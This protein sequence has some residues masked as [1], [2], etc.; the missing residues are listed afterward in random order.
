LLAKVTILPKGRIVD[1][2]VGVH[3]G[4]LTWPSDPGVQVEPVSRVALGDPAS[5]SQ[6]HLGSHTGTHVDPP[7]HF[8]KEGSTVDELPLDALV[9]P[10]S[11]VDLTGTSGE[12]T[13][14][15]LAQLGLPAGVERILLKTA[16]SKIWQEA[17]PTFPGEYIALSPDAAQ[18][19]VERG[20]RLVGT[21]FLSIETRGAPG[22]PVH[23]TLLAA[24]VVIVEGLNLTDV[25]EGN[26][27]LVCLPL[28]I[29][30][31][32]GAPAR[33]ILIREE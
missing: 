19:V 30:G 24:G 25:E 27:G 26:Y 4:M 18:W 13:A 20:V 16:N 8:I 28:K 32:D 33:A 7:F 6:L 21:D 29:I 31:G 22:H 2:S 3:P 15:D 14:S 17:S 11:V 9:G 12:I 10:A 23:H 1:I 5:V